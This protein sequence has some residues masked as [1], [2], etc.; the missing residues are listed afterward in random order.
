MSVTMFPRGD[1]DAGFAPCYVW[2][3]ANWVAV[4][5]YVTNGPGL[6]TRPNASG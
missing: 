3:P 1:A 6:S 5:Q 4:D 2:E